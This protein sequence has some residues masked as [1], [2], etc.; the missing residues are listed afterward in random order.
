LVE[1]S[2]VERSVSTGNITPVVENSCSDELQSLKR[3]S[4]QLLRRPDLE[5][6]Q[7]PL[8]PAAIVESF[9]GALNA[10]KG[11]DRV[12]FAILKEINQASLA[13]LNGIYADLNKHLTGLRV[14]P[15]GGRSP[16]FNRGSAADSARSGRRIPANR[17]G[18][19][20]ALHPDGPPRAHPVRLHP[21]RADHG[22]ARAWR[23]ARAVAG[24]R[25]GLRSRWRRVRPVLGDSA[26][27]AQ[28]VARSA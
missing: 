16:I 7:N 17:H 12:K 13:D 2:V 4:G 21:G 15:A 8:A 1:T 19:R 25:D 10:I 5:T 23:G 9:A 27:R 11:E 26:G 6:G 24:R 14:I 22:D 18:V 28:R 3:R 20:R